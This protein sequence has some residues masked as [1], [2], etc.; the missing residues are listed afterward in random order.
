LVVGLPVGSALNKFFAA[1]YNTENMELR[2][3]LPLWTHVTA[4][5]VVLGLVAVSTWLGSR[6]LRGMDLA[7]ATKARE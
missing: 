1:S 3:Y 5:A 2:A 7:Q 4:A 6:R